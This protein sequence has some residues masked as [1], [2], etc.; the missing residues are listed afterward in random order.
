MQEVMNGADGVV[1]DNPLGLS[2]GPSGT[3]IPTARQVQ[4]EEINQVGVAAVGGK[5]GQVGRTS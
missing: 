1:S 4:E 5:D 2:P 3:D